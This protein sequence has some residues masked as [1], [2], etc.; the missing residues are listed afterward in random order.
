MVHEMAAPSTDL[1]NVV[2]LAVRFAEAIAST[3]PEWT[4]SRSST[5]ESCLLLR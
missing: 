1:P 5:R 2:S 3:S 4:Y